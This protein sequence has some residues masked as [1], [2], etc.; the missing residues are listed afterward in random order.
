MPSASILG[1]PTGP[2]YFLPHNSGVDRVTSAGHRRREEKL[3][4]TYCIGRGVMPKA[5]S[6]GDPGCQAACRSIWLDG[7]LLAVVAHV[8]EEPFVAA[9]GEEVARHGL[10][11][12]RRQ[13]R[14]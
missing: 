4:A 5:P 12:R 3:E 10:A 11:R 7:P 9:G 8:P 2:E 13:R 6:T 1:W 14:R